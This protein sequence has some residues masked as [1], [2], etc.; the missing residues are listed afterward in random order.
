MN[1]VGIHISSTFYKYNTGRNQRRES[2]KIPPAKEKNTSVART[3]PEIQ[4]MTD[5]AVGSEHGAE[6]FG[7]KYQTNV[8]YEWKGSDSD[9]NT[10]DVRKFLSELKKDAVLQQYQFFVDDF[11]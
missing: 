6:A 11:K 8:A 4:N 5:V 9:I 1:I 3:L 7:K 2:R 10:V